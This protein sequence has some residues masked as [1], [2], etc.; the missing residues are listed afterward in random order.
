MF[1][2]QTNFA[3]V[4]DPLELQSLLEDQTVA[5]VAWRFWLGA[6]SNNG[7]QGQRNRKEIGAGAT[8]Y[9]ARSRALLARISR[10]RCSCVSAR[11]NRQATQANQ[12]ATEILFQSYVA[13]TKIDCMT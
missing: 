13:T 6:H 4:P 9:A 11:Q 12:T 10:P 8:S 5:C 1:S 2:C 7:G 3:T